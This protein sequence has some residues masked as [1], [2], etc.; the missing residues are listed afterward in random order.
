MRPRLLSL[1]AR[2]AATTLGLCAAGVG[3]AFG[4]RSALLAQAC[5]DR[6]QL[7]IGPR[8]FYG[9]GSDTSLGNRD[10]TVSSSGM[11]AR[12][13]RELDDTTW[14]IVVRARRV[15]GRA[16]VVTIHPD[17]LPAEL[18]WLSAR[19]AQ[20]PDIAIPASY[21]LIAL[22][23][24]PQSTNSLAQAW[25]AANLYRALR[26]PP[27]AALRRLVDPSQSMLRRL[28]A[29]Y[30][31]GHSVSDQAVMRGLLWALCD[32]ADRAAGLGSRV[33][34]GAGRERELND[35]EQGLLNEITLRLRAAPR[36]S[37]RIRLRE[38]VPPENPV[39]GTLMRLLPDLW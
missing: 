25:L 32:V 11:I 4:Q 16:A 26:L 5:S 3:A 35:D 19:L 17:S 14:S 34:H 9:P 15:D 38:L 20:N 8:P 21:A 13:H 12:L 7:I 31:L 30:A 37:L 18:N 33:A 29:A 36:D 10:P 6:A 2:S 39:A 27:G 23:G 24:A 28:I 22:M 1:R